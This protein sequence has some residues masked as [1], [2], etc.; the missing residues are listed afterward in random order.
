MVYTDIP[1]VHE[2]DS[3]GRDAIHLT[4]LLA[5]AGNLGYQQPERAAAPRPAPPR[6]AAKAAALVGAATAAAG[7]AAVLRTLRR[8]STMPLWGRS[9]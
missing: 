7:A 1:L 6:A 8:A 4:E 3:G 5:T 9:G 2:L